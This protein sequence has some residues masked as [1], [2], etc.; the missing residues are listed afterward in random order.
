MNFNV[1]TKK[2]IKFKSMIFEQLLAGVSL[3]L[4]IAISDGIELFTNP[5]IHRIHNCPDIMGMFWKDY[6]FYHAAISG[7]KCS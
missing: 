6:K 2:I 5:T 1:V 3:T 4:S 7:F